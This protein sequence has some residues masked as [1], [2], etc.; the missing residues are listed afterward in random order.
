LDVGPWFL[1]EASV[2]GLLSVVIGAWLL[3]RALR[4]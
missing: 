4:P 3:T 2:P 1:K